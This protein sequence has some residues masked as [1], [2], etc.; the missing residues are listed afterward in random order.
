MIR[1]SALPLLLLGAL[2]KAAPT[3][4]AAPALPAFPGVTETAG[5]A[6]IDWSATLVRARSAS[7]AVPGGRLVAEDQ[8]IRQLG[9]RLLDGAAA[10]R[11]DRE[12]TAGGLLVSGSPLARRLDGDTPSAWRVVET[13]YYASGKV[14]MEGEFDLGAWLRP[15][16]VARAQ[17][18]PPAPTSTTEF[19]G[20]LVDARDLPAAGALAPRLLDAEG[21][22]LY[23]ADRLDIPTARVRTPVQYVVDPADPRAVQ[24]AGTRP[25]VVRATGVRDRVDLVIAPDD[26]ARLVSLTAGTRLLL[27]ARVVL[28]L[29][30]PS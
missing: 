18:R 24:R 6:D 30:P 23:D 12:T 16:V 19:T 8:A 26:A 27:E 22:V 1:Y 28:V 17:V 7:P 3:R 20:I 21:H 9:P 25:L 29:D 5:P 14:E 11:L 10:A 4:A 15:W 13:R 2:L